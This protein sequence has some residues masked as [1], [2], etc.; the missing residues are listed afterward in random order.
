MKRFSHLTKLKHEFV[1]L[2]PEFSKLVLLLEAME[3]VDQNIR[4]F[5]FFVGCIVGLIGGVLLARLCI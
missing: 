2:G 5:N 4:Y 3:D 1:K